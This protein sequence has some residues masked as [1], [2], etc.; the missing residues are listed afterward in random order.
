MGP[1]PSR[2]PPARAHVVA[3][4]N[5]R[6][7]ARDAAAVAFESRHR[8]RSE[9]CPR[10]ARAHPPW[11]DDD[12]PAPPRGLSRAQIPTALAV[13][14]TLRA[15][16]ELDEAARVLANVLRVDPRSEDAVT[17]LAAVAVDK[18][19][20]PRDAK[21][22][23]PA[24][25]VRAEGDAAAP[26]PS[27][28]GREV[29]DEADARLGESARASPPAAEPSFSSLRPSRVSAAADAAI[30]DVLSGAVRGVPEPALWSEV[31]RPPL[32]DRLP[33]PKPPPRLIPR[34]LAV[35]LAERR[36]E[37]AAKATARASEK[38]EDDRHAHVTAEAARRDLVAEAQRD[39]AARVA[40]M[41]ERRIAL[42]AQAKRDRERRRDARDAENAP[43]EKGIGQPGGPGGGG[44]DKRGVSGADL[45]PARGEGRTGK[46]VAP[47]PREPAPWAARA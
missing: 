30:A 28:S 10:P 37:M 35:S 42:D 4:E 1:P 11:A 13:A 12:T 44:R 40:K 5:A 8:R 7:G 21:K 45:E 24:A 33:P 36:A 27:T 14:R 25:V 43:P 6:V 17:L 9:D 47:K 19:A 38:D 39:E 15:D 22:A 26:P 46:K 20:R 34:P 16:G 18:G 23:A 29:E 3:A 32:F 41:L 2:A 31:E